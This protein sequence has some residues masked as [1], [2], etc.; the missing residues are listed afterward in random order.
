MISDNNSHIIDGI[1]ILGLSL[2]NKMGL[3]KNLAINT[4]GTGPDI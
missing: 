1:R 4:P 2:F 3:N